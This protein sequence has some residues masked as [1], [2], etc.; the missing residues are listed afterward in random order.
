MLYNYSYKPTPI[1]RSRTHETMNALMFGIELECDGGD[2]G[3]RE[4]T[5]DKINELTDRIYCKKDG[6]LNT[7]FEMVSHPGTLAYH[8]YEMPWRGIC[9]KAQKAGFT[10]HDAGTCGLQ[11]PL[12]QRSARIHDQLQ[13]GLPRRQRLPHF[14]GRVLLRGRDLL[15][16]RPFRP[17]QLDRLGQAC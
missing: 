4:A 17:Q 3:K 12:D 7:G 16:Q 14:R 15:L 10:S 5:T 13:D 8:Q 9:R 1:F 11:L 6:S 2:I